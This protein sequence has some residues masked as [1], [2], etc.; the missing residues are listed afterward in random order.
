MWICRYC[1]ERNEDRFDICMRCGSFNQTPK[2]ERN[3]PIVGI[4]LGVVGVL[5]LVLI[6]LLASGGGKDKKDSHSGDSPGIVIV[7][8]TPDEPDAPQQVPSQQAPETVTGL[9]YR[10]YYFHCTGCGRHNPYS[11]CR[12][13][14]ENGVWNEVWSLIPYS[15]CLS[16]KVYHAADKIETVSLGD[17]MYWFFS[18]GNL[19]DTADGTKDADGGKT[20]VIERLEYDPD[21]A[22]TQP[23]SNIGSAGIEYRYY[24]FKCGSCGAHNL[25]SGCSCGAK[26]GV[27]NEV[28]SQVPYSCSNSCPV[29]GHSDKRESSSLGDGQLWYFSSGNLYDTAPGTK[30]ADGGAVEVI[31]GR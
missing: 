24:Y 15:R 21:Y 2:S 18:S 30:D 8:G 20:V 17:N 12:C 27:W 7:S 19:N 11:V 16:Y 25:Y 6:L 9:F 4:L 26:K 28:W 23:S 10:Y 5:L 31:R 1:G 22:I 14:T 29:P 13:G 3:V